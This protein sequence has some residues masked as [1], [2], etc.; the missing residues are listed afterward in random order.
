MWYIQTFIVISFLAP[1][2]AIALEQADQRTHR[3]TIIA[4][5]LTVSGFPT[6]TYMT[7]LYWFDLPL[8]DAKLL[9]F[10][11]LFIIGAYIRKYP[12]NLSPLVA[13]L[14]FLGTQTFIVLAD[15]L[16]NS[17]YS[18]INIIRLM[19]GEISSFEEGALIETQGLSGAFADPINIIV[20]ASS[21]LMLLFF[22]SISVQSDFCVKIAKHSYGAYIIHVF[23]I[24]I[25]SRIQDNRFDLYSF[26]WLD[27]ERYPLYATVFI[28]AVVV[29]SLLTSIILSLIY[30]LLLRFAAI[31]TG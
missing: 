5:L 26:V 3:L 29:F 23:W 8:F 24:Q 16:Y 9:L 12:P 10:L 31:R 7:G 20:I 25:F 11:T 27:S 2:L 14:L 1:F 15:R 22:T 13:G 4:L 17:R 28:L 30:R 18:P 19:R 21:V 6:F